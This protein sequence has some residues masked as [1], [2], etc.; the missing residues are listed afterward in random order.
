MELC[1]AIPM[2]QCAELIAEFCK[3]PRV[4]APRPTNTL[5]GR[6]PCLSI[7]MAPKIRIAAASDAPDIAR[8]HVEA[9]RETYRGVVPDETLASLSVTQRTKMWMQIVEGFKKGGGSTQVFVAELGGSIVG[10]G[11]C[12]A[13]RAE[14]LKDQGYDGEFSALYVLHAA[15]SRGLGRLL[16]KSMAANLRDRGFGGAGLWVLR[17]NARARRFY[18][19]FGGVAVAEKS[20]REGGVILHEVGYGWS[21]WSSLLD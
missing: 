10:F 4:K 11:S 9:W 16:M 15:Q 6:P 20:D 17:D 21:D 1:S 8:V 13:Q 2:A 19:F 3:R 12:G 5:L 18:E 14:T 7:S